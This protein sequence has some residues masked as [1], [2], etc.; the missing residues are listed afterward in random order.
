M[1]YLFVLAFCC[2]GFL[3]S[4]HQYLNEEAWYLQTEDSLRLYMFEFGQGDPVVVLHGGYGSEHSYMLDFLLPH[5]EN[6]RFIL[7][8]QRGSLRSPIPIKDLDRK[9]SLELLVEDL[10]AI[11]IELGV[12][13]MKIIAHSMGANYLYNYL[14]KYPH[15]VAEAIVI[16]GFIPKW[17]DEEEM[18]IMMGT[19]VER[20][21][22]MQ[23]PE[24]QEEMDKLAAADISVQ[25][26]ASYQWKIQFSAGQIYQ[27]EKWKEVK[28]LFFNPEI[29]KRIS[30]ER[31]GKKFNFLDDIENHPYPITFIF[32]YHEFGDYGV[33]LH[34]RW[35]GEMEG[36]H[37]HILPDAGHAVWMDKPQEFAEILGKAL[38]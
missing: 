33:K 9:I 20:Q 23:R 24:I 37:L 31:S 25:K 35:L 36:V 27:I 19:Q 32:G 16:S 22:F 21:K 30:P 26:K 17:P 28:G 5:Q 38:E 8:D 29:N 3:F 11:R 15:R 13:R 1:K 4:Q 18:K 34:S 10:E 14:E 6:H 7:F 2:S 12:E